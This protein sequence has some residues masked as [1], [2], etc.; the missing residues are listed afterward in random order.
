MS[1]AE[2]DRED[3]R[4]CPNR[5][6]SR[7]SFRSFAVVFVL[8]AWRWRRR[9]LDVF[10]HRAGQ[11]RPAAEAEAAPKPGV[12]DMEPFVVNLADESGKRFLRVNMKLLT[13]DEEQAAEL[14]EDAVDQRA[15]PLRDPRAALAAVRRAAGDARRQGRT[16][17]G[18]RRARDSTHRRRRT[19]GDRC[20]LRRIRCSVTP[21]SCRSVTS[22]AA[23][24]CGSGRP[25]SRCATACT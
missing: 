18:D 20:P 6:R 3:R 13:W 25:R 2:K 15:R 16:Q 23:S 7:S 17:E 11:A 22:R 9:L 8:L 21:S 19:E 10:K 12:V 1:D 4:R 14:K 5:R 24:T